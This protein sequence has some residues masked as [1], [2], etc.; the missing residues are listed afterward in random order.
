[1][2]LGSE[3]RYHATKE[4][5]NLM[6]EN[7]IITVYVIIDDTL[8]ALGHESDKRAL[9]SDAEVLTVAILAA[10]YFQNHHER[11]LCLLKSSGY[12]SRSLS[13]SRF[14][15]RVH[16]LSDWLRLILDSLCVLAT[17]GNAFIIDSMP[18]PVC[19]R[20]RAS[21]CKKVKGL[22]YCGYCA[23][24]KE[25]FYGYRLHLICNAEGIPVTFRIWP[26]FFHD[27]NPAEELLTDL[28]PFSRV[29]ADKGY[30]SAP[31]AARV[32][33]NSGVTLIAQR[34][35][36]MTPLPETDAEFIRSHRHRIETLNSQLEAMGT[37]RLHARTVDGFFIKVH[38]AL[39]ALVCTFVD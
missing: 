14:N 17:T 18:L 15:R 20:V 1:M 29:A 13:I 11:T 21:R 6:N 2:R 23:A 22:A 31:L 33:A 9:V 19:R 8:K 34:R 26:A 10:K 38:A 24:K 35:K 32:L 28:P 4:T 16:Q 5:T 12:L 27:I 39:L 7:A 3:W 25:R 30:I 36:N 37:Q